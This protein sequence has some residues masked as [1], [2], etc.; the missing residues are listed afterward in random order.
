MQ[1]N[2][3]QSLKRNETGTFVVMWLNLESAIQNEISEK[4]KNNIIH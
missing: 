3:T 1:W 4:E 2:I